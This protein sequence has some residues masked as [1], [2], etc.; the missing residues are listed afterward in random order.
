MKTEISDTIRRIL[1]DTAREIEQDKSRESVKRLKHKIR[2][3]IPIRSFAAA[4]STGNALIAE[5]KERSP[6]QGKMKPKNFQD[7]TEAYRK[8]PAVKAISVLTSWHHFGDSMRVTMME[9]VKQNTGKPVLRKDFI[10]EEYQVYQARAYGADA[11]LLMANI[12]DRDELRRLSDLAFELRMDVLFET[13]NAA[14][15][16][17]LPETA[18]IVGINSRSFEG[19]A[20][21]FQ[22]ARLLRRWLGSR[23]D[24]SVDLNRFEYAGR[25]PDSMIKVAESGVSASNCA[26]VFPLGFD[27]ILVGTSLLMDERGVIAALREFETAI[28]GLKPKG[29]PTTKSVANR[30]DQ[31]P[32]GEFGA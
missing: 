5:L 12:L 29:K 21:S 17:E 31:T 27:A 8:S 23:V 2:D 9:A 14:E 20:R 30:A 25:V 16:E 18:K 32:P 7:A 1:S 4:L 28:S 19:G 3:A 26:Q 6:S 24:R 22:V 10:L 13:H 15:L 11:I